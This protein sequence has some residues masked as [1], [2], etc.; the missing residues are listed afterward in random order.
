M[1]HIYRAKVALGFEVTQKDFL[2]V[3]PAIVKT[4]G[5]GHR[6]PESHPKF[7]DQD[8]T[9]FKFA[10][11]TVGTKALVALADGIP[12]CLTAEDWWDTLCEDGEP[13]FTVRR[14]YGSEDF[15]ICGVFIAES[16]CESNPLRTLSWKKML[17]KHKEVQALRLRLG[18]DDRPIKL[19]SWIS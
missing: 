19:Y 8:G 2:V 1:S 6:Q 5:R 18:F 3:V 13:I 15:I 9:P 7:C 17:Q 16:D 4:C 14:N 12:E 11:T 10:T